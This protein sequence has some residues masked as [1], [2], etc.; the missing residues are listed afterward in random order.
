MSSTADVVPDGVVLAAVER[1]VRHQASGDSHVPVWVILEHLDIPRRSAAGR[2]V[3][4][5]IDAL[6]AA[7]SLE[8]SRRHGAA[9]WA[10]SAAGRRRLRRAERT[11]TVAALPEA[12][13]HRVWR[14]A[15]EAG[16]ARIAGFRRA[17]GDVLADALVV[18]DDERRESDAWFELGARLQHACRLLGSASYCL[19]EWAEPDD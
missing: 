5:Q 8:C 16:Q 4:A 10:L 14:L 18:L 19:R 9:V 12:P 2:R 1:A 6:Q 17:V 11:G 3:R 7:G 13:Q 15:R